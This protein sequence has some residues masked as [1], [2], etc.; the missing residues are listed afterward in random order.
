MADDNYLIDAETGQERFR[1][2]RMLASG[3]SYQIVLV[4]D[5][6]RDDQM[7]CARATLYD[8]D[9]LDDEDY[10]AG[11]RE[12]LEAQRRFLEQVDSPLL[13]EP[14][15]LFRAS[16]VR[17]GFDEEPVLVCEYIPG[18]T[19]FDWVRGQHPE[20][21]E[22]EPALGILRQLGQFLITVHRKGYIYRDLDPR[23]LIVG[24]D[25]E[26]RGLVGF[27]NATE[28]SERPNVHKMDY[29]DAPYVAPE[30]RAE[31]SGKMLRPSAD[32]YGLGVLL[33]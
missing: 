6:E 1:V 8:T 11:R 30:A 14:V 21:M 5:T 13:P 29:V 12:T 15:T 9:R 19:L 20:G 18:Q 7:A 27:G 31:R 22:V 24:D 25:G 23:H 10:R 3:R 4:D 32:V 26:L 28:K 16:S 2:R 17:G 33:S